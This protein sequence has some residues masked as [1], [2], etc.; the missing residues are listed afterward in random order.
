M[1]SYQ[2]ILKYEATKTLR[3]FV[4]SIFCKHWLSSATSVKDMDIKLDLSH[5]S[6]L[7]FPVCTAQCHGKGEKFKVKCDIPR[8]ILNH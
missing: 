5:S 3:L 1:T 8:T 6:G 2:T 4:D 7:L